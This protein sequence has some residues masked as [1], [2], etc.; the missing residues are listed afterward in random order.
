MKIRSGPARD[1]H[2]ARIRTGPNRICEVNE[3][4]CRTAISFDPYHERIVSTGQIDQK[5]P[6]ISQA[7][8]RRNAF[9]TETANDQLFTV[10][11][12]RTS[13]KPK[14]PKP[15]NL[16]LQIAARQP[17]SA[18]KLAKLANFNLTGTQ[19][20]DKSSK[21]CRCLG[22]TFMRMNKTLKHRGT[23]VT[24]KEEEEKSRQGI[25]LFATIVGF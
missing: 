24:E 15:L 1:R 2:L 21:S 8:R 13:D 14:M 23:E 25:S 12:D 5:R 17:E 6:S 20:A 22:F 4:V 3:C 11:I 18:N 10:I 9:Q 19:E 16:K 7:E